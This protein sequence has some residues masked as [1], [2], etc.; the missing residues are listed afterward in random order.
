MIIANMNKTRVYTIGWNCIWK[1]ICSVIAVVVIIWSKKPHIDINKCSCQLR[2]NDVWHGF[3]TLI[4]LT[5]HA[6]AYAIVQC[7]LTSANYIDSHYC[8][9]C[10]CGACRCPD[11]TDYNS[12]MVPSVFEATVRPC[13]S[14]A[15]MNMLLWS[16]ALTTMTFKY[17]MLSVH[18]DADIS[19]IPVFGQRTWKTDEQTVIL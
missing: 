17:I 5:N 2:K 9:C 10:C 11:F 18:C 3:F 14:T 13:Y 7:V 15:I 4:I 16:E 19:Y 6:T 1:A 12:G 8:H